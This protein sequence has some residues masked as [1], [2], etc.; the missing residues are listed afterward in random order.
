MEPEGRAN[1][2]PT[3]HRVLSTRDL[4]LLNVAA[5]VGLR[6]LSTAAKIGPSSLILWTLGLIFFFVP[7]ALAVLELSS[8]LPGEGGLY[9]WTKAAFGDLHGFI[10]GWSYWVANLVFFPSFLLFGAGVS[11]YITGGRWLELAEN[12]RYNA[13][14]CLIA[15]WGI[16]WLNV[17]GLERAKWLQNIGGLATWLAAARSRTLG[18]KSR[19][20]S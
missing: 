14:Y 8:R 5:I 17:V 9:V 16:T 1:A 13:G 11:L 10:A 6:W 4:V 19:V 15:L 20:R 18:A 3:L 7:A 2:I 12:A